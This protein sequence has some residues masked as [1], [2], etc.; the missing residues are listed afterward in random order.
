MARAGFVHRF[1]LLADGSFMDHPSAAQA[2]PFG[3]LRRL[4]C[5]TYGSTL[6]LTWVRHGFRAASR[7]PHG[8][9]I[10]LPWISHGSV[11][12]RIPIGVRLFRALSNDHVGT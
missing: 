2:S 3:L 5:V 10:G 7:I 6:A 4:P 11:S 1:G 9:P 12:H 8:S